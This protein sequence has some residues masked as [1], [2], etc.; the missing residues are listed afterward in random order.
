MITN[1]QR[2][3]CSTGGATSG[4]VS[5][6]D[7]ELILRTHNKFRAHV[8]SGLEMKGTAGPQPPAANMMQLVWDD[9]LAALAQRH[10]DQCS[11]QHDC[12]HCRA[13]DRF[14]VGQNL[15]QSDST[16]GG[17]EADWTKVITSW[18]EEVR[19]FD[20][21]F[22]DPFTFTHSTGH[23]TQMVWATTTHVGC[24]YRYFQDG[25]R[26]KK[27]Y[28]CNYGPAG[29]IIAN[30]MYTI[31]RACSKCPRGSRCSAVYSGLCSVAANDGKGIKYEDY[32]TQGSSSSLQE[33]VSKSSLNDVIGGLVNWQIMKPLP[34][35]LMR[36]AEKTN[37]WNFGKYPW[38]KKETELEPEDSIPLI[39][40]E[41]Q[42]VLISSWY[43]RPAVNHKSDNKNVIQSA[44]FFSHEFEA[45]KFQLPPTPDIEEI[46]PS[47][48]H[49]TK[50]WDQN[51]EA[52]FWDQHE[53]TS[54]HENDPLAS[55]DTLEIAYSN[56]FSDYDN[57]EEPV[58]SFPSDRYGVHSFGVAEQQV[59]TPDSYY[60]RAFY[61]SEESEY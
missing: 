22:I 11:S 45:Q 19:D 34:D 51:D 21:T 18:Y 8:A 41:E 59:P 16:G 61:S 38:S 15:H 27:L 17:K 28:T 31:A 48:W 57:L 7:A 14:A 25:S 37:N 52:Q 13:L 3:A 20:N 5:G 43:V 29:N 2:P 46:E 9:E 1:H 36:F 49:S 53:H 44:D 58:S 47:S 23:Y 32:S 55:E 54:L 33:I 10:A 39:M 56:I 50:N 40:M 24:G 42:P 30:P 6:R 26:H 4:G 35:Q 12:N 60:D